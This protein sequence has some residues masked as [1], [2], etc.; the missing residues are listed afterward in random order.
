[1]MQVK[2]LFFSELRMVRNNIR[3]MQALDYVKVLFLAAMGAFFIIAEIWFFSRIFSA[4]RRSAKA[5]ESLS[6]AELHARV[7]APC[8][9]G[10][11]V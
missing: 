2:A 4:I 7:A 3:A 5:A 6:C 10:A 11:D 9:P 8:C 1:M